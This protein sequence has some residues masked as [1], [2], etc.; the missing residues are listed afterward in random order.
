MNPGM[1][2]REWLRVAADLYR[3]IFDGAKRL[4]ICVYDLDD[5][6]RAIQYKF[7]LEEEEDA[8]DGL[9]DLEQRVL[10]LLGTGTLLGKTIANRLGA[11]F[12][13][14]HRML[15]ATMVRKGLLKRTATGYQANVDS[16]SRRVSS[17]E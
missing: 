10:R 4:M 15:L 5:K 17:G 6:D 11:K 13:S 2:R 12:D 3:E 14:S 16:A 1:S 9:T 8:A 7:P